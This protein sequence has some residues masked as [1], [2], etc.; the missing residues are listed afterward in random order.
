[1]ISASINYYLLLMRYIVLSIKV[2][3]VRSVFLDIS[4][5]FDK[6]WHDGI[7]FKLTQNDILENLL[8]LFCKFL[9]EKKQWLVL[10]G[11]FS[12]WKKVNAG[13]PQGTIIGLLLLLIYINDLSEGFLSNAKPFADDAS[14][15][16]F[17]HDIQTLKLILIKI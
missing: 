8:N 3:E 14:L 7:I 15:F 10:N 9:N 16:S 6:V 11:K 5:A 12:A 17:I 13:V 4:E 1:M 2:V